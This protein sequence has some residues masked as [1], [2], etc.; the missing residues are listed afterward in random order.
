MTEPL[1]S[2][3][4]DQI[5]RM[6]QPVILR[7]QVFNGE[8]EGQKVILLIIESTNGTF[9]FTMPVNYVA[10]T[11]IPMLNN[12]LIVGGHPSLLPSKIVPATLDDLR[13]MPQNPLHTNGQ[14][15]PG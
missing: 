4:T 10:N 9:S 7:P 13:K 2:L 5:P 15:G 1:G 12:G 3:T 6:A 14:G 8:I 11:L